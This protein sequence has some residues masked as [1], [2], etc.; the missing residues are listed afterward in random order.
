MAAIADVDAIVLRAPE[1][2]ARDF[3]SSAETVVVV[4]HDEDGNV[5]IGEADAP[6]PVIR[7]LVLMD[8]RHAWSRG[9][10]GVL[11]PRPVRD[12]R[13]WPRLARGTRGAR[14]SRRG[15]RV[16]RPGGSRVPPPVRR[17]RLRRRPRC[18]RDAEDPSLVAP[19]SRDARGDDHCR[20]QQRPPGS[21]LPGPR[22][23]E[24]SVF[25]S[26]ADSHRAATSRTRRRGKIA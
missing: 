13:S 17:T 16:T 23:R 3:D 26:C 9:L 6:A 1:N 8:D 12:R 19:A 10:R 5:G 20:D 14:L 7:E 11:R 2:D 24:P 18:R 22:K 15:R 25:R 4:V 21:S